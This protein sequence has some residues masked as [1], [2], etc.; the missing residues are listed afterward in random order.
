MASPSLTPNAVRQL[1]A[2][3]L[4]PN[5]PQWSPVLQ[6]VDMVPVDAAKTQE[7]WRVNVS[8]GQDVY[9]I[10][11]ASQL[12]PSCAGGHF[13]KNSVIRAVLMNSQSGGK[14]YWFTTQVELLQNLNHRIGNVSEEQAL[15]RRPAAGQQQQ[16]QAAPAPAPSPSP[17]AHQQQA[18]RQYA[19][20]A[21]QQAHAPAPV[22]QPPAN[23]PPP[24]I[25]PVRTVPIA[26]LHA[27]T[28]NWTIKARVQSKA[29]MKTFQKKDGTEGQLFS[30]TL[31]DADAGEIRC[32]AFNQAASKFHDLLQPQ[33]VYYISKGTI[34]PSNLQ[35]AGGVKH[36]FQIY[37]EANSSVIPVEE[38]N[39]IPSAHYSF[40]PIAEL[41]AV[42]AGQLVDVLG[43]IIAVEDV[44]PLQS[45]TGQD[46]KKRNLT[47]ADSTVTSISFTLWGDSAVQF[48]PTQFNVGTLMAIKGAKVSDYNGKSIGSISSTS[49]E[50]MPD[51][52]HAHTLQGWWEAEGATASF[53]PLSQRR[54]PGG[55]GGPAGDIPTAFKNF[56][57]LNLT[58]FQGTD[59]KEFYMNVATITYIPTDKFP[60]YNSCIKCGKKVT[61]DLSGF[62]KCENMQCAVQNTSCS[63]RYML[64]LNAQDES[65]SCWMSAFNEIGEKILGRPASELAQMKEAGEEP[66]LSFIFQDACYTKWQLKLVAKADQYQDKWRLR[67]TVISAERFDFEAGCNLLREKIKEL[68]GE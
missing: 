47:L 10:I 37:L 22:R 6:I 64:S 28:P 46:L 2:G 44:V 60:V 65:G 53:R 62:Y 39:S 68:E 14:Q 35:Y 36:E 18:A 19:P 43:V 66:K 24:S 55:A 38:D 33:K 51:N 61:W 21:H 16:H 13:S 56:S 15:L 63:Y 54:G 41:E 49:I 32:T 1:R 23:Q 67:T 7:R 58:D 50:Y 29:N 4:P 31:I 25:D 48:D 17:A 5:T 45:K 57:E 3:T 30:V 42:P 11:F 20:P 26:S 34:K 8:D 52:A 59:K 12:G 27:Y 40:V 9:Q